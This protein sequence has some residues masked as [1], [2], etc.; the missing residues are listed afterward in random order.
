M[1]TQPVHPLWQKVLGVYDRAQQT[2]AATKT[3]TKIQLF[4]DGG[5]TFVLR[6]ASALKAKP[7][8]VSGSRWGQQPLWWQQHCVCK[9][10]QWK[11]CFD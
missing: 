5:V 3:D 2:G 10:Q 1:T 6:V 9:S 8:G 4:E 7:K 11:T